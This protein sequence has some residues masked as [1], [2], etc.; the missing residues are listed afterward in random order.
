VLRGLGSVA[1]HW[2]SSA[3][4]LDKPREAGQLGC[5]AR[6]GFPFSGYLDKLFYFLF[7]L[8]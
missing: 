1:A 2:A 8:F 4:R 7:P 3:S 5:R 6:R